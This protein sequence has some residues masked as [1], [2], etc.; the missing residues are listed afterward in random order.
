[1]PGSMLA[2]RKI[3]LG[4]RRYSGERLRNSGD[5]HQRLKNPKPLQLCW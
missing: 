5:D 1:L 3:Q 4:N 2:V